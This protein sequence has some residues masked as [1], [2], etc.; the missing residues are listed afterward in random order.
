LVTVMSSPPTHVLG[1][2]PRRGWNVG[3]QHL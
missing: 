1:D 3:V 2:S